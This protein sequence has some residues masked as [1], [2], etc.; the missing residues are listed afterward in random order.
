MVFD[1]VE[2]M[3]Y[4]FQVFGFIEV[5]DWVDVFRFSVF[6]GLFIYGYFLFLVFFVIL[7]MLLMLILVEEEES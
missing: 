2:G 5:V 4:M 3:S 1:N 6:Q 7:W